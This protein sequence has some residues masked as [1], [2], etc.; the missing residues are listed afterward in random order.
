MIILDGAT[1]TELQRRGFH[2][3]APLWT[4]DAALLAPD[5][6][7][8]IHVDYLHAGAEV[9]TANT[10]RTQP[11]VLRTVGRE[12]EA[13]ALTQRAVSLAR[14]ACVLAGHG[15]VAGSMAPLEDCYHPERVPPLEVLQREHEL[16][17]HHLAAAGVDLILVETMNTRREAL[18]AATAALATGLPVWVSLILDPRTADLLS[19]EDL[20]AT[21]E[22]LRAL[23]S[24]G[25]RIEAFAVNCTPAAVARSALQRLA[26]QDDPRSFGAYAN[27]SRPDAMGAWQPDPDAS[28]EH[29]GEWGRD[30]RDAGAGIL[31]GC[32][33][34]TPEHIRVLRAALTG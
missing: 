31:G 8:R 19:G 33:G 22:S 24:R 27:A 10:F 28:V 2:T 15:R 11:Y 25:R 23:A 26:R 5:L 6:L 30:C 1:G 7:R 13:A 20:G 4:A 3:T 17:A 16:H 12:L 29:F 34:T 18:A 14:D 9:V 21:I 32:C